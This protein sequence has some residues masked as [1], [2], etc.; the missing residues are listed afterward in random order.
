[1]TRLL[2]V[3]ALALPL[4]AGCEDSQLGFKAVDGLE[5]LGGATDTH[6][7]PEPACPA[8]QSCR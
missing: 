3:C 5:H 7:A 8:G 1:M 2:L 4:L 6:K